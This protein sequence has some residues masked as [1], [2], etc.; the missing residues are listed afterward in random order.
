MQIKR[1]DNILDSQQIKRTAAERENFQVLK[2]RNFLLE[3]LKERKR[4]TIAS[5][6]Q[7]RPLNLNEKARLIRALREK[8]N[9]F[10]QM[11]YS[12]L[13][14]SAADVRA[15]GRAI[16]KESRVRTPYFVRSNIENTHFE[17][18]AMKRGAS[19]LRYE[20]PSKG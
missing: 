19:D 15:G 9:Y 13:A 10:E 17:L 14:S 20:N 6:A 3:K 16:L 1:G 11:F 2:G 8:K 18:N 4:R 12:T 7:R 5:Q